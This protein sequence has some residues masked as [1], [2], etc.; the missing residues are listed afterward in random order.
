LGG[1]LSALHGVARDPFL[2]DMATQ[3]LPGSREG[4][5]IARA[6]L[7]ADILLVGAAELAFADLLA[8]PSSFG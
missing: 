5:T 8:D 6:Q 3:P 1:F 2:A 4:V 7:R